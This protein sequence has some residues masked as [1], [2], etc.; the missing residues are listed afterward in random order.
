MQKHSKSSSKYEKLRKP[1]SR[2]LAIIFILL[3]LLTAPKGNGNQFHEI[4]EFTGYSLLILAALGR[5]W[6]LIYIS[7]RKDRELC[8]EGPY[9]LCRNPLYLFSFIGVIGFFAALQS[10]SLCLIASSLYL[11]YYRGVIKS[12]EI[13]LQQLFGAPCLTYF[14][15]TPRFFPKWQRPSTLQSLIVAPRIIER[16]MREVVWFLL[17]IILIDGVELMHEGGHMILMTLPF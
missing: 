5:I 14:Q 10:I 17:A 4:L 7:G 3:A 11:V 15:S 2:L 9:S 8:T 1:L 16:G 6:C 12:E 13:R